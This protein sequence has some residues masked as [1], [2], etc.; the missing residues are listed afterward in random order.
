MGGTPAQFT[1]GTN[2]SKLDR[3]YGPA[4]I[5][6]T[7]L[8]PEHTHFR[9]SRLI[10]VIIVCALLW[11]VPMVLL[12]SQFGWLGTLTQMSWFFTK[13]AFLTFGGAYAVPPYVYQGAVEYD[14][15]LNP[16]QMIDGLALVETLPG[17]LIMIVA[18]VGF[19]GSYT[20]TLFGADLPLLADAITAVAV[21]WFTFLPS[22]LFILAGEALVE[23]THGNLKLSAPLTAI[24]AAVVG[25]IFNLA[26]FLYLSCFMAA[27][28][29]IIIR[30]ARC[31]DYI[32]CQHCAI[33]FQTQCH[34]CNW[35][36][37][38]DGLNL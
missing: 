7:T 13:A 37:C 6:D 19:I 11:I 21:T 28:F 38:H 10:T 29:I 18:F 2:P 9:W 36:M 33:L 17:P 32:R 1:E 4:I 22:F 26:L 12:V 23:T 34:L 35:R 27:R 5:D 16:A 30:M 3:S 8:L 31:T 15:W 14:G 20:N 25:V 24:T